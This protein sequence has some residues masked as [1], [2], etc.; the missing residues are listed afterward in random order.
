MEYVKPIIALTGGIAS[1]KSTV[2]KYFKQIGDCDVISADEIAQLVV[3]PGR[4]AYHEVVAKFGDKILCK[5]DEKH[6]H[7]LPEINRKALRQLVF[8]SS[9]ASKKRLEL[10]ESIIHPYIKEQTQEL[11]NCSTKEFILWDVPLLYEKGLY[12]QAHEVIAIRCDRRTQIQRSLDRDPT[13]NL[14][15]I[16]DIM[17]HQATDEQRESIAKYVLVNTGDVTESMLADKV[18]RLNQLIMEGIVHFNR[19]KHQREKLKQAKLELSKGT[20]IDDPVSFL[21]NATKS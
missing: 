7:L 1:G 11:I 10:L 17:D 8:G 4:P 9:E 16:R 20:G 13:M 19:R 5:V 12:N 3:L 14:K 6:P 15:I 21:I 18:A 2:T